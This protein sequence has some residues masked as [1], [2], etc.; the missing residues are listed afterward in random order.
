VTDRTD[1]PVRRE[2]IIVEPSASCFIKADVPASSIMV[3]SGSAASPSTWPVIIKLETY[4]PEG[5]GA[6]G[7]YHRQARGHWILDNPISTPMS[8]YEDFKASRTSFG[9]D[10]LGSLVIKIYA[11]DGSIGVATGFGGQPACWLIEQHFTRFI[12]GQDPRDINKMWD[13]MYRSSI[14][15]SSGK[16]LP[17]AAISAVDLALWDLLGKI[18]NEPVYK[19]IGGQTKTHIPFYMTGPSPPNAK[20]MGFWGAK[21]PLPYGPAEGHTGLRKNVEFLRAHRES[22]GPDYPIMV[23]CW[24]SLT[25]PYAIE[26]AK[27]C[28]DEGIDINW[29]EECLHPSDMDGHRKLKEA[30]PTVKWTTGEHEYTRYGF[31]KL[32]TD[33]SIDIIQPDVMWLGGLTELMRVAAMASAYDVPVVPHG[34]GPYSYHPIM[35]F[36]NSPFCEIIASDPEGK[37][38]MPCF[39]NL[40]LDEPL[41]VDGKLV[42]DDSKPGFGMTLNPAVKLTPSAEYVPPA[43]RLVT[44]VSKAVFSNGVH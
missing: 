21:V 10:V 28:L 22:V 11:S 12:I 16:G 9:I 5:E 34:S 15:Y 39:G 8:G 41:P 44:Q 38:V 2:S 32:I 42:L 35:T 18:R 30:L 1:T 33:R 25:V 31:R 6:G 4:I 19:M 26:L 13:Q 23:D 7:D 14:F 27:K 37:R 36:T 29:W 24:M 43:P 20:R 3:P 40:F 17:V